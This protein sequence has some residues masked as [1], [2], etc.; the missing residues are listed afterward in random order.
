MQSVK[1]QL[2]AIFVAQHCTVKQLERVSW[3]KQYGILHQ[4]PEARV[5]TK[6]FCFRFVRG[7]QPCSFP[8]LHSRLK[9]GH[10]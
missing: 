5:T 8:I 4:I 2:K 7:G 3:L 10:V 9:A 1:A 6:K